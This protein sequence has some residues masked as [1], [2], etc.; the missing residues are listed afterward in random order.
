[1]TNTQSKI[2]INKIKCYYCDEIKECVKRP[3]GFINICYDCDS[4]F[5]D[6][7]NDWQS[8]DN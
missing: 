7:Y 5:N 8:D 6:D 2:E 3:I 4:E 1:M